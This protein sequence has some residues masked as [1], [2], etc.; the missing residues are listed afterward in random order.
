ML[1]K[2][3]RDCITLNAAYD[4][5]G[6]EIRIL[7]YE[8]C[9]SFSLNDSGNEFQGYNW[10]NVVKEF[11]TKIMKRCLT[12]QH[13]NQIGN[14]PRYFKTGDQKKIII[15]DPNDR[16]QNKPSFPMVIWPGYT[17]S[18]QSLSDGIFL[19]VDSTTKFLA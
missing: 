5:K 6:G 15:S 2:F 4:S 7:P 16:R 14:L 9:S 13:Y 17:C 10:S 3:N 8:T 1:T 12:E 19:N 11:F 18:I